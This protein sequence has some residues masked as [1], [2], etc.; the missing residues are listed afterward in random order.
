MNKKGD[1]WISA[2]LYMAL[3]VIILTIVLATSLP[4]INKLK[5]KNTVVQTKNLMSDLD[6]NIRA[7]YTEGPGS[8]RPIEIS[9]NRGTFVID[10]ANDKETITWTLE[11]SRYIEVEP[12]ATI[13]EG[14]L[15]ISTEITPQEGRYKVVIQ[16]DY[17]NFID[18]QNTLPQIEGAQSFLMI[19]E[20]GAGDIPNIAINEL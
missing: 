9:I 12:E 13:E 17:L 4:V 20:G 5:D 10:D 8:Q 7:L 16:L 18:L 11:D 2:V 14:H 3:G 1:I 19:N 15:K 6:Q